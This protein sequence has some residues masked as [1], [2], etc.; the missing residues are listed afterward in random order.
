MPSPGTKPQKRITK[1]QRNGSSRL[2]ARLVCAALLFF[3]AWQTFRIFP[4]LSALFDQRPVISVDHA[5]HLYHGYLGARFLKEHGTSWGYDPFFMAGY[6]KTPVYDSSSGPAELFEFMAGADYSPRAYKL[7]V[8]LL[9]WSVPVVVLVAAHGYGCSAAAAWVSFAWALWY[10]WV[11]FPAILLRSGLVAFLW[12][13]SL[14]VLVPGLLV[15]LG[16]RHGLANLL[17]LTLAMALGLEAHPTFVLMFFI[18]ALVAWISSPVVRSW[19][20]HLAVAAAALASLAVT[21]FWWWPLLRFLHLKTGSATFMQAEFWEFILQY[22]AGFRDARIPVLTAL[23]GVVGLSSWYLAGQR[24]RA[25]VSITQIVALS[26]L[27]F[28]GSMWEV[29]R[30]LEPIRF[31]VPLVLAWAIPAGQGVCA[32]ASAMAAGNWAGALMARMRACGA[33]ILLLATVALSTPQVWWWAPERPPSTWQ[34]SY[35]RLRTARPLAVGLRPEMNQ[36]VDWIIQNTDHSARILLEDQL[37]LW[38]RTEEESIHWTP[39]LPLLTGRQYVG[40]L[41][42]LAFI[43]HHH[44]AFGD[45]HL[46]GQH[47]RLWDPGALRDFLERYNIGWV[48]TWSRASALKEGGLPLSTDK[49]ASLPFCEQVAAL[50]R[51][52]RRLD[53]NL[54]TVF[55][56]QIE[57]SYF[58]RGHG[59]VLR[60]DYNRIELAELE[61][62]DGQL[63]LKYHWQDGLRAQPPVPI[64]RANEPNDPIGFIRIRSRESL[65]RLTLINDYNG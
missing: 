15:R 26:F 40:G 46:A 12:A 4:S 3:H 30:N 43:R 50:P 57:H 21:W 31:Q 60:A 41:Y 23:F 34:L 28:A 58:I 17:G 24:S 11:G 63:V 20:W 54:Y 6:P 2:L 14:A 8:A 47:I 36:L 53:E 22:Y 35:T 7:G 39:L 51:L 1:P 19:R 33:I 32:V 10:C 64:E 61:P 27:T 18:P 44:V 59:R 25:L 37:R 9:V 65:E 42:H 16:H 49:F 13:A 55:R 52:T 56:V 38:E 5:I 62:Q 45:W 29:T 48:I